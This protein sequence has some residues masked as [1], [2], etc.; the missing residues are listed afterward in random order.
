MC[1]VIVC[2]C[3]DGQEMGGGYWG[4]RMGVDWLSGS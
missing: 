2:V 1:E 3:V 4:W